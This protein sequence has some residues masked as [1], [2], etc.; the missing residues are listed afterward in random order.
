MIMLAFY[1]PATAAIFLRS[2]TWMSDVAITVCL[3][4]YSASGQ[5]FTILST[6]P[7]NSHYYV[8][9]ARGGFLIGPTAMPT[10]YDF[11]LVAR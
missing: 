2:H 10:A 11:S 1:L 7:G 5:P 8:R 6:R 4:N 3:R 9:P